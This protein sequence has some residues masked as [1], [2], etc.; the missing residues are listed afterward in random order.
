M[1]SIAVDNS[2]TIVT[3]LPAG[4]LRYL[5]SIPRNVRD[6]SFFLQRGPTLK[7]SQPCPVGITNHFLLVKR[8]ARE[9]CH[10]YL[11]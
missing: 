4:R 10:L 11:K 6:I 1:F 9:I 5:Y 8:L 3:C 7:P 2:V